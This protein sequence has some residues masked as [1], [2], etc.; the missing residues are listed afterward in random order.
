MPADKLVLLRSD[1]GVTLLKVTLPGSTPKSTSITSYVV[2]SVQP[3]LEL[4]QREKEIDDARRS[5]DDPALRSAN[6][7]TGY[8]IHASDGEIGHVDGFLVDEQTWAIRYL[9]VNTSNWWI[10]H[11]VLIATHWITGVSWTEQTLSVDVDR[12]CVKAAPPYDAGT[13]WSSELDHG[14]YEHYGRTGYWAGR[15]HLLTIL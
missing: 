3:S 10:G 15:S 11:K 14:L 2:E 7:V 1:N 4:M 12:A 5:R 13:V 9:I 8:H 6:E